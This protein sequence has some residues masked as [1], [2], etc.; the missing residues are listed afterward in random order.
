MAVDYKGYKKAYGSV[1]GLLAEML[2]QGVK[3]DGKPVTEAGPEALTAFVQKGGADVKV[4]PNAYAK[5]RK[6]AKAGGAKGKKII[7]AKPTGNRS[8]LP[9]APVGLS[10]DVLELVVSQDLSSVRASIETLKGLLAETGSIEDL[11]RYLHKA[12]SIK[13]K[14]TAAPAVPS[15]EGDELAS[16]SRNKK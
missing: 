3:V 8:N 16:K 6:A 14:L 9:A 5:L 10:V 11:E 1:D 15:P 12:E 2:K 4:G 13:E 7:V